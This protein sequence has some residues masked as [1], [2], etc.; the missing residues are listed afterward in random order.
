[1]TSTS[2]ALPWRRTPQHDPQRYV[3]AGWWSERTALT[4]YETTVRRNPDGLAVLDDRGSRRTHARLWADSGALADELGRYGVAA[5]SVVLM[6]LPNVVEWQV[7]LLACL[8]LGAVPASLP[9]KTDLDTLTYI[10]GSVEPAAVVSQ[11]GALAELASTAVAE[12]ASSA[13]VLVVDAAGEWQC[14]AP[15]RPAGR[16]APAGVDHVMFTSSTTGRPKCVAHS[17][18]T[19]GA[20]N[21]AFA[22]RFSLG[23]EDALFMPSPLGHSV[24]AWHGGRLA[25]WTGAPLIVQDK[26]DPQLAARL[27]GEHRCAFTAAATP[28]LTDL[29]HADAPAGTRFG[30]LRTFL[31]GGAPVP[32][33]LVTAAEAESPGTL[34]SVLWG[35]T[36]GG[37]TTCRPDSPAELRTST[38]G[39]PLPGLELR[40]VTASGRTAQPGEEGELAMRGP[41]VCLGY[42]GQDDLFD[43]LLTDDG[44]FRTGDLATVGEDGY[45]RVTGRLK[46]LIIRGGV[47]ISP[48]P[49]EDALAAHPHVRSVAVIGVPD[50][51]LGERLGAVVSTDGA[52]LSLDDVCRW[53]DE[54]G[55]SRRQWPEQL[56]TVDEMPRTAAGKIKKLDLKKTLTGGAA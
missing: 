49:I 55:L 27:L 20:V 36:E 22:E 9:V 16:P 52:T 17:E 6:H 12:S 4:R 21:A 13:A 45:L 25:L 28:F 43:D 41:G 23:A 53:V 3:A 14:L 18:Q 2:T 10:V 7:L 29:V 32:P 46:D 19:L 39:L 50:D 40:I 37:V 31:C 34:F 1:M 51:R 15:G 38:A 44:Y 5:R 42:V 26:W 35:M 47:N 24:G 30:A 33:T 11:S 56:F 54:Y 8:R 48:L